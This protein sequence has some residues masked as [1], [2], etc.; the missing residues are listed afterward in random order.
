MPDI[1]FRLTEPIKKYIHRDMDKDEFKQE[2]QKVER[3]TDGANWWTIS[4]AV[5]DV[6]HN[7]YYVELA[8]PLCEMYDRDN[9]ER[10]FNKKILD[11]AEQ[12]NR[13]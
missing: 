2:V 10:V 9:L 11:E 8:E 1:G 4:T 7:T 12:Q 6:A 5:A 3:D 13:S